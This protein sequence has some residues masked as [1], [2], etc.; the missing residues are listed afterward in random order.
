MYRRFRRRSSPGKKKALRG[1][2]VDGLRLLG[3]FGGADKRRTR[4]ALQLQCTQDFDFFAK[5]KPADRKKFLEAD[6]RIIKHQSLA[7]LIIDD[8]VIA[9]GEILRDEERLARRLPVIILQ[10]DGRT[11]IVDS[12]MKLK[13]GQ[14]IRLVQVDTAVFAYAPVLAALKRMSLPELSPE[15]FVWDND[16]LRSPPV[17]PTALINSLKD[18]PSLDIAPFLGLPKRIVLDGAQCKSLL[19]ALTQRVSLIQGPPGEV[20]RLLTMW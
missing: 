16:P 15:L 5:V 9:F 8:Q 19:A 1:F 10:M 3:V 12:L 2:E 6:K 18:D 17:E 20:V 7:C 13:S 4:W 14:S 11:N